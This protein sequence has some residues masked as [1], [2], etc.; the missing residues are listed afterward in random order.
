MS[1]IELIAIAIALAMDAFAVSIASG[2]GLGSVSKRQAFRLAWHFGL[3]QGLMPILGWYLGIYVRDYTQTFAPWIAFGLLVFIGIKMLQEAFEQ[4]E[5][6]VCDPTKGKTLI[7][8]SIATSIDALA[9]GCSLSLVGVSI[10]YPALII[11][12]VAAIFTLIGLLLARAICS[13]NNI[14]KYAEILGGVTLVILGINI[15]IEHKSLA[16]LYNFISSNL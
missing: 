12:I 5:A 3:F 4:D 8:L 10:W 15:L 16:T 1:L 7:A 14:G 11:G 2:I 13:F 6:M 9:V